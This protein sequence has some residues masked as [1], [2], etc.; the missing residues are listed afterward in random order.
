LIV[1]RLPDAAAG[2]QERECSRR[3]NDGFPPERLYAPWY[4][5]IHDSTS[6]PAP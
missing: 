1:L 3:E 4:L 2:N 6:V 5:M